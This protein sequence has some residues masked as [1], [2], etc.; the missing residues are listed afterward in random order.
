VQ[1][2]SDGCFVFSKADRD[3][4]ISQLHGGALIYACYEKPR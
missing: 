4:V 1:S 2:L 3:V